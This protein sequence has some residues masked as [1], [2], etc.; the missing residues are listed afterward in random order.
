MGKKRAEGKTFLEFI[1]LGRDIINSYSLT[2]LS[3]DPRAWKHVSENVFVWK[4]GTPAE[5]SYDFGAYFP[6]GKRPVV[7][8]YEGFMF[9]LYEHRGGT[10]EF[11]PLDSVVDVEDL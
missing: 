9:A 6:A 11:T 1:N 10:G 3:A 8:R 7:D 5:K 2:A 4:P